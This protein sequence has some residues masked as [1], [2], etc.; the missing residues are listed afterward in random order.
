MEPIE[1]PWIACKD[2]MPSKSGWYEFGWRATSGESV[3]LKCYY[4]SEDSCEENSHYEAGFQTSTRFVNQLFQLGKSTDGTGGYYW[5]V[6]SIKLD[7]ST[8]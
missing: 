3:T 1:H 6:L 8:F 5:R 7:A 2:K 4:I